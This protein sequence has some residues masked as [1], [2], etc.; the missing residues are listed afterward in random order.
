MGVRGGEVSLTFSGW[1]RDSGSRP[2]SNRSDLPTFC[3]GAYGTKQ[4]AENC[5]EFNQDNSEGIR[6]GSQE[7]GFPKVAPEDVDEQVESR[8][9]VSNRQRQVGSH[10]PVEHSKPR[11]HPAG[12]VLLVAGDSSHEE[13]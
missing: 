10:T 6:S 1:T 2:I 5:H 3:N 9:K 11:A 8:N 13:G 7:L 12:E 4:Q